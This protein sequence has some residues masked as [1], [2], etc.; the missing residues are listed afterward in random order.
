M[1]GRWPCRSTPTRARDR[2]VLPSAPSPS[3]I[4]QADRAAALDQPRSMQQRSRRIRSRTSGE[5]GLAAC[6][7]REGLLVQQFEQRL[8]AGSSLSGIGHDAGQRVGDRAGAARAELMAAQTTSAPSRSSAMSVCGHSAR[9]M[10][11]RLGSS[12]DTPPSAAD[13]LHRAALDEMHMASPG[14]V[15]K[16]VHAADVAGAED[17]RGQ[18]EALRGCAG[19]MVHGD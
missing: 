19:E 12:I 2:H 5:R 15:F 8:G 7:L 11:S 10:K 17:A 9:G 4:G 14:V 3:G 13:Q 18:R 1:P 16:V 6:V